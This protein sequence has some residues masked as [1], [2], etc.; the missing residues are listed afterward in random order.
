[1][2]QELLDKLQVSVLNDENETNPYE[3]IELE[4]VGEKGLQ[5]RSLGRRATQAALLLDEPR[6]YDWI[7]AHLKRDVLLGFRSVTIW[8]LVM[9]VLQIA[10]LIMLTFEDPGIR[11]DNGIIR[12]ISDN[13]ATHQ[14]Y[15]GVMLLSFAGSFLLLSMVSLPSWMVPP[16]VLLIGGASLGGAGVVLFH[17]EFEWQHIGCA[18]AFIAC[19]LALH[20][21]AIFTGPWRLR[22]TAR[23]IILIV[24]TLVAAGLFAGF[25]IANKIKV[26]S[27]SDAAD[28]ADRFSDRDPRLRWQWW[29]SGVA[30]YMLYINMCTLN[31]FVGQR[32]LEHTSWSVFTA[33]PSL[34]DKVRASR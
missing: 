26:E 29:V 24:F 32:I 3:L 4:Y 8:A 13:I 14:G 10:V 28:P 27:T 2:P 5:V 33:L 23:D 22:H 1:M 19:G 18:A 30:E 20:L 21:I 34:V 31:I 25:L 6:V 12:Y 17:G 11:D 7:E 16:S 15:G 9:V